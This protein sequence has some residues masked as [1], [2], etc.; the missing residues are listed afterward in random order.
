MKQQ[1]RQRVSG[2]I[3]R[4]NREKKT[5]DWLILRLPCDI[6]YK[7]YYTHTFSILWLF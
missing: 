7:C 5:T 4:V 6:V 2:Y 1:Q 3:Q